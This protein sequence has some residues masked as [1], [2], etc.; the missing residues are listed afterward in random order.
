MHKNIIGRIA[1]C[2][3]L[4]AA[5]ATFA[6]EKL[7][8]NISHHNPETNSPHYTPRS[9]KELATFLAG[10]Q[11][12]QGYVY[13]APDQDYF[14]ASN[15][16]K[17]LQSGSQPNS[18][19]KQENTTEKILTG[20]YTDELDRYTQ[21]LPIHTLIESTPALNN[22]DYISYKNNKTNKL[23]TILFHS[24]KEYKKER[25]IIVFSNS[26][27]ENFISN[28]ETEN[29]ILEINPDDATNLEKTPQDT[30]QRQQSIETLKKLRSKLSNSSSSDSEK[31][32]K[33]SQ[34][35]P[36]KKYPKYTGYFTNE[37]DSS[38]SEL[39]TY[40]FFNGHS[41]SNCIDMIVCKDKTTDES[42]T[43]LFSSPRNEHDEVIVCN[44]E[45][46]IVIVD[47][48]NK[49]MFT[50][51][52]NHSDSTKSTQSSSSQSPDISSEETRQKGL[53]L[54]RDKFSNS[55]DSDGEKNKEKSGEPLVGPNLISYEPIL[56]N[57]GHTY[58]DPVETN[59]DR[60]TGYFTNDRPN[61]PC[62]SNGIFNRID[63]RY[64]KITYQQDNG[65][66][67]SIIVEFLGEYSGENYIAVTENV[68]GLIREYV[69][70]M[71]SKLKN[72]NNNPEQ[73]SDN[74]IQSS[75]TTLSGQLYN[76]PLDCIPNDIKDFY[77]GSITESNLQTCVITYTDNNQMAQTISVNNTKEN[78]TFAVIT[79]RQNGSRFAIKLPTQV[80]RSTKSTAHNKAF[81]PNGKKPQN[82]YGL[83][84]ALMGTTFIAICVAL[85]YKYDKLPDAFAQ[86]IDKFFAQCNNLI[87]TRFSS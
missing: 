5:N 40:T 6:M 25:Y 77:N 11:E 53:E 7:Q 68:M 59:R 60:I 13:T 37:L 54:L 33:T 10:V 15:N 69:I 51:E 20:H 39:P 4:I 32:K 29:F 64:T 23:N 58:S 8:L 17:N 79:D 87:P 18:P 73:S 86:L 19:R 47:G 16:S 70:C 56:D 21:T 62:Y 22:A 78:P 61:L 55:S 28:A 42:K 82:S 76:M 1:V 81:T 3:L 9:H 31:D 43:I 41:I 24:D 12:D 26:G 14:T 48:E 50:I 36:Q 84:R 57:T 71:N 75:Q 65:T 35:T 34:T 52:I 30:L 74:T 44:G 46:Y 67:E 85:A 83:V 66:L 45:K 80:A 49:P 38:T 2:G 63:D 27:N 72:S